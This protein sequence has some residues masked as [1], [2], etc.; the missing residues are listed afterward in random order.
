MLTQAPKGTKD[1]LPDEVYKWH[2]VE[3]ILRERAEYYGYREFRTPTFEHTEL[4]LR[5]VGDTTDVVQKEMYTFE[6][7]GNRSITLKPEGTASTVRA[8]LEHGLYNQPLPLK[9]YYITPVF[10]Y[11]RPQAG[12]L[13][14]HHQFGVEVFGAPEATLDAE[15]IAF[16]LDLL[17]SLNIQGLSVNI[18]SIGCP[19][20]RKQYNE[21]LKA[22]LA[23]NKANLC[24]TCRDRL[25][26]NALR[27]L[28]CKVP[29]CGEIT[30]NAPKITDYLCEDCSAHFETLKAALT[31][32][33]IAYSVDPRI[34]RGLDYYVKTVFEGIYT[35][36][37]GEKLTV[38]GGGRYD[39]LSK[40]IGDVEVASAG[41]GMGLERLLMVMQEQQAE[42]CETMRYEVYIASMG[43]GAALEALEL[44]QELRARQIKTEVNHTGKSFKAQLKYADKLRAHYV[45]M[46]GEDEINAGKYKLKNMESGEQMELSKEQLL[47]FLAR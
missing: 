14:E 34:V 40:Q 17:A 21:A 36:A 46:I 12:R 26:R 43:A 32:L 16:V 22:F 4:F 1:V 10:R 33:N 38:C 20:C 30:K 19:K 7:K 28:D 8:F 13:R 25:D 35:N 31:K 37:A 9:T 47:S 41:F 29:S 15:L 18:N 39:S 42:F 24:E 5:S 3:K 45:V 2:A 6:D 27:V 44:A 23:D 11:E